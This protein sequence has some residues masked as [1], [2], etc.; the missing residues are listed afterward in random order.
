MTQVSEAQVTIT[1]LPAPF[2]PPDA[3]LMEFSLDGRAPL[4]IIG[5]VRN[6]EDP[7]YIR[8]H[9]A[10]YLKEAPWLVTLH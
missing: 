5:E 9:I 3:V 4:R 6:W 10:T 7:E 8:S 1:R 2:L